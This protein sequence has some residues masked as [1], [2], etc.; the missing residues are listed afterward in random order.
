MNYI[1]DQRRNDGPEQKCPIV[2]MRSFLAI[3]CALTALSLSAAFTATDT[4]AV[5][6]QDDSVVVEGKKGDRT[7]GV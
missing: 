2:I 1:R 6:D 5:D 7:H 4:V 3:S